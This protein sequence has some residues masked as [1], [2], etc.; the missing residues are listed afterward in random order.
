MSQPRLAVFGWHT[1][2]TL[3][4][5]RS[6]GWAGHKPALLAPHDTLAR[7]SRHTGEFTVL[8]ATKERSVT[9]R[10]EVRRFV[11]QQRCD[12]L[13]PT[14][15]ESTRM[16]AEI[17]DTFGMKY[18]WPVGTPE[19]LQRTCDKWLFYEDMQQLG[20]PMP[21]TVLLESAA[22]LGDRILRYPS[23]I[24][25]VAGIDSEGA[26]KLSLSDDVSRYMA[27]PPA[28]ALVLQEYLAGQDVDVSVLCDHGKVLAVTCQ[29][30][31]RDSLSRE[32][33]DDKP[34]IALATEVVEKLH[35]HGLAHLDLRRNAEGKVHVLELNPRFWGSVVY[36]VWA[37]VNFAH[38][39]V[40]LAM[41]TPFAKPRAN[42]G[43][44]TRPKI[45]LSGLFE[46][47]K[48]GQKTAVKETFSDPLPQVAQRIARKKQP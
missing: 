13:I 18:R 23:F 10:E 32:I 3:S 22:E 14:D 25:P 38:L 17:S 21:S 42:L 8:H 48:P 41:G 28:G 35:W 31:G 37:G 7:H 34:A 5:V 2:N 46:A 26:A 19:A 24:K 29:K 6:L 47:F 20:V 1:H 16:I 39:G 9:A 4:V 30:A 27:H 43:L 44:F 12:L 36:S 15:M 33:I 11:A 45:G 40:Q